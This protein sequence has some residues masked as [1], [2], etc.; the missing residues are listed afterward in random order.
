MNIIST[1]AAHERLILARDSLF[2]AAHAAQW[3]LD[4]S[5]ANNAEAMLAARASLVQN[6]E[7]VCNTAG[8]ALVATRGWG[9]P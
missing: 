8:E 4:A 3:L 1:E 5:N 9:T 7:A 2:N 6:M